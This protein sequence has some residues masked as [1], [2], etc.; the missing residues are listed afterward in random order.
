MVR[1][2]SLSSQKEEIDFAN[3]AAKDFEEYPKHS[4]FGSLEPGSFFAL[5]WGMGED[6]VYVLKLDENYEPAIYQQII[7]RKEYKP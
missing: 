1:M 3:E 4:S 2:V 7:K 6:C 5:R